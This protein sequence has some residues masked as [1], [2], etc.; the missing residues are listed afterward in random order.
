[1]I[2]ETPPARIEGTPLLDCLAPQ[3]ARDALAD[4]ILVN[5]ESIQLAWRAEI[6]ESHDLP[7]KRSYDSAVALGF[8]LCQDVLRNGSNCGTAQVVEHF[9][10]P[11]DP[12]DG[13]L[14]RLQSVI[15]TMSAAM[16]PVVVQ[17]YSNSTKRI[18][19]ALGLLLFAEEVAGM[20]VRRAACQAGLSQPPEYGTDRG[21][22]AALPELPVPRT[23]LKLVCA[24]DVPV[25]E[26]RPVYIREP[27]DGARLRRAVG[28]AARNIGLGQASTEDL[29]LAVGEAASNVL[30]HAGEGCAH[31]WCKGCT[32][33][34]RIADQGDGIAE[35]VL[36]HALMPGWSSETSLGM[37]FT[38]MLEMADALWLATGSTGTTIC[39]EKSR[40]NE[41]SWPSTHVGPLQPSPEGAAA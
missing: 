12:R 33:Y 13:A 8:S 10:R 5:R 19:E 30:K 28:V 9:S 21:Y 37:G 14:L 16:S 24:A 7:I 35:E 40:L 36:P 6:S 3:S 29:S 4:L 26:G 27:L 18:N 34:V 32:V 1:M 25:P 15:D 39:I 11:E 20:L 23:S 17:N 38:L 41:Q 22:H 2:N 31:V